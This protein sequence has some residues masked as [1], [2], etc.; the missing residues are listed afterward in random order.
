MSVEQTLSDLRGSIDQFFKTRF[1]ELMDGLSVNGR[2]LFFA[3]SIRQQFEELL[4][5]CR[6]SRPNKQNVFLL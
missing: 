1:E 3:K 2:K 5:R 4:G 6:Q